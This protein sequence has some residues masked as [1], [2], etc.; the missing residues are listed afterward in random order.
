MQIA[1]MS[2]LL[3][4]DGFLEHGVRGLEIALSNPRRLLVYYGREPE[5]LECQNDVEQFVLHG[6]SPMQAL[7]SGPRLPADFQAATQVL[8]EWVRVAVEPMGEDERQAVYLHL[9]HLGH[10]VQ[11]G[12]VRLQRV[13]RGR[14]LR[15]RA[16]G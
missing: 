15:E 11:G 10:S 3:R 6:V 16:G 8:D 12:E 4:R 9:H 7:M 13:L 2:V 1:S 5:G 14:L